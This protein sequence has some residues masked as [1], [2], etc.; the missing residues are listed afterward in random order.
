[1]QGKE[2]KLEFTIES[3]R[4]FLDQEKNEEEGKGKKV[5]ECRGTQEGK[6]RD[7][8][9]EESWLKSDWGEKGWITKKPQEGDDWWTNTAKEKKKRQ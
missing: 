1:M 2:R 5:H 4:N 3:M 6:N 7:E 9:E 8:A